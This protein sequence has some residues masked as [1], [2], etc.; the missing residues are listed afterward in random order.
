ME[1]ISILIVEDDE[2]MARDIEFQLLAMGHS[3]AGHCCSLEQCP[4]VSRDIKAD[5]IFL[6]MDCQSGETV[7]DTAH[8]IRQELNIPFVLV[9]TDS[10]LQTVSRIPDAFPCGCVSKPVTPGMLDLAIKR[11]MELFGHDINP[12][13]T[14]GEKAP[15]KNV[16][17]KL[18]TGITAILADLPQMV[19]FMDAEG[20][21]L[22]SNHSIT[23]LS[24]P[25]DTPLE[26]RICHE[27]LNIETGDCPCMEVIESGKKTEREICSRDGQ[28]YA[29]RLFPVT[30]E[31][32]WNSG[33]IGIIDNITEQKM[34]DRA[35]QD[36][37]R[38][39]E[40]ILKGGNLGFW[41][42]DMATG[43]VIYNRRWAA[44][45]GYSADDIEPEIDTW[46]GKIHPDDKENVTRTLQEHLEGKN[47]FFESEHRLLSGTG[48]WKWVL[49]NGNVMERDDSG[50]AKRIAGTVLD[51][52]RRRRAEEEVARLNNDLERI[53][54]ER[55]VRLEMANRELNE[56][57]HVVSHDLKTPLRGINQL[58]E[59]LKEDYWHV[60]DGEG[61]E[62]IDLIRSRVKRMDTLIDGILQYSRVG[63]N[64]GKE[65]WIDLNALIR[66]II[67]IIMPREH[68]SV[69][70]GNRLPS[71]YAERIR[72]EQVFQNLLGN[73]VRYM[74]KE[75]GVV[76]VTSS[77]CG[78]CHEFCVSDNG[79]GIDP[80][81]H[82][83][84]FQI[85]QTLAPAES[86]ESTGIGLALVKKIIEVMGGEI[87]VQSEVGYG[88][89]F[90]FTLP[91]RE[92]LYE[93]Q[94]THPGY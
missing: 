72:L 40:V 28:W 90:Y 77:D 80:R 30:G 76:T 14:H 25:K 79:P 91:M 56:F 20:K 93:E 10:L 49:M 37:Q 70:I 16:T 65:E 51:I 6:D 89:S 15:G 29:I 69:V 73:A 3:I 41:D 75:D 74:D 35:L 53:V 94:K 61:R 4:A 62:H 39:L 38:R 2:S 18:N 36:N 24:L 8:R 67:E 54:E 5:L 7:L 58:S 19:L 55:T 82:E 86:T 48:Q 21:I 23:G 47:H 83:K 1:S 64:R 31:K 13:A 11:A 88:T 9:T 43:Y 63:R 33:I 34:T 45:L 50:M 32:G 92:G 27:I 42:W 46:L 78:F 85:F 71:V 59:W 57:A 52:S 84:I 60:L 12:A 81:Y 44:I 68:I 22:E 26:G 17:G 87:R 66:D